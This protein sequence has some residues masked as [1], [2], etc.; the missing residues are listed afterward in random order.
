MLSGGITVIVRHHHQGHRY[1]IEFPEGTRVFRSNDARIGMLIVPW[2][3]RDIPV[4]DEPTELIV[5][6]AHSGK[7][8]LRMLCIETQRSAEPSDPVL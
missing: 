7:L 1:I 4:F 2:E 3:G 5:H 6:L 8:G